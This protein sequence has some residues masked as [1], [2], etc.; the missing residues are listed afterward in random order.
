MQDRGYRRQPRGAPGKLTD[1]HRAGL[2]KG[3]AI[4]PDVLAESGAESILRGRDL[5]DVFSDRQRRR[6]PGVLFPV[7]RPNGSES[8]C[9]RP[10]KPRTDKPGH[11]YEQPPKDRGGSGNVLD[12]LPSQRHLITDTNVPVVFVEGTKKALS[13]ITAAR[14]SGEALLV[15]AIIGVWNWL[16]G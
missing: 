10:D 9:F 11:K 6:G 14:Q 13:L 12:V 16:H 7:H 15:V 5:P 4:A 1:A 3:S 8:W 2:E